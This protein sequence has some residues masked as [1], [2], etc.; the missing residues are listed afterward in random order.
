MPLEAWHTVTGSEAE[1]LTAELRREIAADHVLAGRTATVVRRCSGCD[2]VIFRL[3]GDV[4]AVVHLTWSGRREP[5]P[6]PR[7]AILSTFLAVESFVDS[8]DHS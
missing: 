5:A 7:T 6:W 1:K 2:D 4:F 3:D 8:H